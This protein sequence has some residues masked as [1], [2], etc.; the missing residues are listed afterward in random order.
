LDAIATLT[1]TGG[2]EGDFVV[3]APLVTNNWQEP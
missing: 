3:F 2:A 1:V